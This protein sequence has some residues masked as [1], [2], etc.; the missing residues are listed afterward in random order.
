[1]AEI[2]DVLAELRHRIM[3]PF[4]SG[5]P[6]PARRQQETT[7]FPRLRWER[8]VRLWRTA[9]VAPVTFARNL[10]R[11]SGGPWYDRVR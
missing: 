5:P 9:N 10:R 7:P 8:E 1:M 6:K 11:T 3:G 2:E 4:E